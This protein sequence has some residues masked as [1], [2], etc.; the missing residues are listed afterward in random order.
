MCRE[1]FTFHGA[2]LALEMISTP[3]HR[4]LRRRQRRALPA[5]IFHLDK[6][7]AVKIYI[8][9]ADISVAAPGLYLRAG[10][11]E[12]A[13]ALCVRTDKEQGHAGEPA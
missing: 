5:W 9:S 12:M 1:K 2:R 7:S 6:P 10:Q 11:R 8:G 4:V 3:G 13:V